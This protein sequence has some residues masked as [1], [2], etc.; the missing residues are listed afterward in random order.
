MVAS[1]AATIDKLLEM[2]EQVSTED[3]SMTYCKE[4]NYRLRGDEDLCRTTAAIK[5]MAP[6][7]ALA[8]I[9]D[10]HHPS[11]DHYL[12]CVDCVGWRQDGCRTRKLVDDTA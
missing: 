3:G 12:K 1:V 7:E 6:A 5:R 4:C 2:H 8:T 10:L 9:R 11:A